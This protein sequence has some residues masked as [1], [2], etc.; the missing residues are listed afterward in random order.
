M[1]EEKKELAL[2]VGTQVR[3]IEANPGFDSELIGEASR[4][5]RWGVLGTVDSHGVS[6][7]GSDIYWVTHEDGSGGWYDRSELRP[8]NHK[9]FSI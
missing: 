8:I 9:P 7:R 1:T 6:R 4:R 3:T 5:R 2:A